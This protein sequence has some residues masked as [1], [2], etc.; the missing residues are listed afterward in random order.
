M[1][2]LPVKPPRQAIA[3]G[4]VLLLALVI[5]AAYLMAY[6][7][8]PDWHQLTIDNYFHLH[9]AERIAEGDLFGDTTYFRAPAYIW[10]LSGLI[11]IFGTSLWAFRICGILLGLASIAATY[12]IGSRVFNHRTGLTAAVIQTFYPC[13]LYFEGELLLDSLFTLLLQLSFLAWLRLQAYPHRR[14]AF[15]CGLL[16]GLASITRPTALP[17]VAAFWLAIA[18]SGFRRNYQMKTALLPLIAGVL[19]IVVPISLRNILVAGDPVLIS[20]QGGVNFYIGNNEEADGIAAQMPQPMGHNWRIADITYIAERESGKQLKP[21]E[22]SSFWFDRAAEWIWNE[23]ASAA[24]LYIKKLY[25]TVSNDEV[26]NN[27]HLGQFFSRVWVLDRIPLSFATVFAFGMAGMIWTWRRSPSTRWIAL[28]IAVNAAL[29]AVFFFSSRFRLPILPFWIILAA[30]GA[31]VLT[32]RVI[33]K[34]R[35]SWLIAGTVIICWLISASPIVPPAAGTSSMGL[36]SKGLFHYNTGDY[37]QAL[38]FFR[39]AL[40]TQEDFP[41]TNLNLAACHLRLGQSDSA[42]FYLGEELRYHPD[43][44]RA[45]INLSSM[46]LLSGNMEKALTHAH[47]AVEMVPYDVLANQVLLRAAAAAN[48][49][50]AA[51]LALFDSILSNTDND[52]Y[53]L[54]E[55]AVIISERGEL[56][57]ARELLRQAINSTRPPIETDDAAFEPHFRHSRAAWNKELAKAHHQLGY[58]YGLDGEFAQAVRLSERAI[59]FDSTLVGAWINLASALAQSGEPGRA[60]SVMK[61]IRQ[62]FENDPLVRQLNLQTR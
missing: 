52:L 59:A 44:H 6:S 23:P 14:T 34:H 24:Y 19:L 4:L 5:R 40:K 60:D 47:L 31:N 50:S 30:A 58:L 26:A 10:Y 3:L 54:N 8:L 28:M 53:L 12:S 62:R 37:E 61:V 45:H 22:V 57:K 17:I 49:S 42:L 9:W 55:A 36:T 2:S 56:R 27:R 18:L 41:E 1:I 7:D 48:L 38:R 35:S 32:A 13:I 29:I 11:S 15:W 51:F 21:G 43:R 25:H 16:F 20:S 39:G 33:S 46:A